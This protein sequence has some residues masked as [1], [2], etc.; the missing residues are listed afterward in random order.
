VAG[1]VEFVTLSMIGE[2]GLD[3]MVGGSGVAG[4]LCDLV[5]ASRGRRLWGVGRSRSKPPYGRRARRLSFATFNTQPR[6]TRQHHRPKPHSP[7]TCLLN[8]CPL[9]FLV[10]CHCAP[11]PTRRASSTRPT[12][13]PS[14]CCSNPW[15]PSTPPPASRAASCASPCRS[16]PT[17]CSSR[18]NC[19]GARGARR[20]GGGT[21]KRRRR[22]RC[23][24]PGG[25]GAEGDGALA[26]SWVVVLCC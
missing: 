21:R 11:P 1:E 6:D 19:K 4:G 20:R 26:R 8:L 16:G 2:H 17:A 9:P 5:G 13:S 25:R 22:S 14:R 10:L 18:S 24:G 3:G 12:G 15:P 7:N 23:A